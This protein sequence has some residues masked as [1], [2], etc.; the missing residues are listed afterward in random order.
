MG[1]LSSEGISPVSGELTPPYL[2]KTEGY[3][4][5]KFLAYNSHF[6]I[7]YLYGFDLLFL[8]ISCGNSKSAQAGMVAKI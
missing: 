8:H 2:L 4:S 5:S 6:D 1:C 7:D 3:G